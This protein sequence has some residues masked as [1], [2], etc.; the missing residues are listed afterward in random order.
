MKNKISFSVVSRFPLSNLMFHKNELKTWFQENF[1]ITMSE[2]CFLGGRRMK[3]SA[4]IF[5]RM[6]DERKAVLGCCFCF[7]EGVISSAM[8]PVFKA[9]ADTTTAK[10]KGHE[11]DTHPL[12]SKLKQHDEWNF[13]FVSSRKKTPI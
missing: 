13:K 10:K 8:C 2:K 7:L 1:I 9:L 12:S 3:I 6:S 4:V 11:S 5:R